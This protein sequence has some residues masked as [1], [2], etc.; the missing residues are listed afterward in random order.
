MDSI[1]KRAKAIILEEVQRAGC[2]ARHILLFGSRAKGTARPDSDWDFYVII[3]KDLST[4][5]RLSLS[6]LIR[7][8]FVQAGFCGDVFIQSEAVVRERKDNTGFLT[9]YA[10]KEGIEI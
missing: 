3:D 4:S 5:E 7:R 10:L 1:T 2:V 9:Y 8:R 6:D